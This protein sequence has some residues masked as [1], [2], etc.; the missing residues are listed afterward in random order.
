[1]SGEKRVS[2]EQQG[3]TEDQWRRA[4]LI[5]DHHRTGRAP[6][7]RRRGGRTGR[8]RP[9]EAVL[10]EPDAA[11]TGRDITL[12]RE[13]LAAASAHPASVLLVC[14]PYTE[15]RAYAT[16]RKLWPGAG[17]L[18]M[19]VGGLQRVIEYPKLGFAVERDV[20]EDVRAAASPWAG[21]ASPDT[22]SRRRN[23]RC[24]S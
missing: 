9:A 8:P 11:D 16:A 22:S 2:D 15:R 6:R 19:L 21:T 10:P 14:K 23:D 3:I 5:W 17:F 13:V 7:P 4:E 1:V 20:P 12:V 18:D 24:G